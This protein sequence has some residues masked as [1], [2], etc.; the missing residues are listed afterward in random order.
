MSLI[1]PLRPYFL[2]IKIGAACALLSVVFFGGCYLQKGRNATA[3]ADRDAT[4]AVLVQDKNFL[5][6]ALNQVNAKAD[7]AKREADA[8]AKKAADAVK[9]ADE[10]EKQYER[11][12]ADAEREL[13]KAGKTPTC[14]IQLEAPLCADLL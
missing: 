7:Q 1:D 12:L 9:E 10:A 14:R 6:D 5:A 3:L 4:I 8:Q 11:G 13:L 2:L